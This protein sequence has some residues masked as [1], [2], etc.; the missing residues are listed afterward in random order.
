V[1]VHRLDIMLI[2]ECVVKLGVV[3]WM[4]TIEV[5][6]VQWQLFVIRVAMRLLEVVRVV[7]VMVAFGVTVLVLHPLLNW[8][9]MEFLCGWGRLMLIKGLFMMHVRVDTSV[10]VDDVMRL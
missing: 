6:L 9:I 4:L 10:L 2:I 1:I 3:A 8:K 7:I 5:H